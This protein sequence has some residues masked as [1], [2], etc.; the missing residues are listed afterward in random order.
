M[1]PESTS[2]SSA[3]PPSAAARSGRRRR[4]RAAPPGRRPA[5]PSNATAVSGEATTTSGSAP[6][7]R[8]PR[9]PSRPCGGRAAGGGAWASRNASACLGRRP[10]RLLRA[11]SRSRVADGWGARIR[12]WDHGTKT[13]CLTAWPRPIEGRILPR[14]GGGRSAS[15]PVA[16]Q[17]DEG[18]DREQH[19]DDD[20]DQR[21]T[22][23]ATTGTTTSATLGE[24]GD[25]RQLRARPDERPSRPSRRRR[26]T[27]PATA[28][29]T[30][31]QAIPPAS[32]TI[33][34]IAATASAI[35][36]AVAPEPAAARLSPCS[37]T[38][39]LIAA[40]TVP[41]RRR[42]AGAPACPQARRAASRAL[43]RRREEPVDGRAGAAD[44]GAERSQRASSS[45]ERRR[46]EVVRRAARARSPGARRAP[47]RRAAR[48]ALLEAG[49]AAA[50]V[51]APVDRA[52]STP[53]PRRPVEQEHRR[54][55]AAGRAA[56]APSRRRGRAAGPS[57]GRTAR[58]PRAS[59]RARAAARRRAASRQRRVRE[60]QRRGRVRAAAAETCRDRDPLRRCVTRQRGSTPR[61]ARERSR[62]RR[63]IVSSA[64][65]STRS[66]SAGS[67]CDRRRASTR[68]S[69]VATSC[70]PSGRSGPT[71]SARLIFAGAGARVLMASERLGQRDELAGLERLGA[72]RRPAGRSPRAPR[73][74][75]RASRRRR[76]A[77]AFGER[78]AAVGE[79]ALDDAATPASSPAPRPA[80]TRRARSRRSAAAG[81]RSARPGGSRF[82]RAVEL[83]EHGHGAVGLRRR[84]GE[85]P[86]GD[87][88]LHHHAPAAPRVGSPSGSRRPAAS[89]CCTAGSRRASSAAGASDARSSRER[90][91][92]DEL[93]VR[94]PASARARLGSSE[95]S[96]STA[97]TSADAVGEVARQ[98]AETRADL[99]H[100][101][102]RL[103]LGEPADHAEDVLV[104]EEV[105]AERLLRRDGWH[106]HGR[107]NAAVALASIC[108]ASSA[109]VLAAHVGEHAN[110]WTT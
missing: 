106:A 27:D 99:E 104:D 103:E 50:L 90:V 55:P 89:R 53:S 101:V 15:A 86:V 94:R 1:S 3:T 22:K 9:P 2:T 95:R 40:S 102:V 75:A 37:I 78:L 44:V 51:E 88:A 65:P 97:W 107:P 48:R 87:L 5:S 42:H 47:A 66:P 10:S 17:S 46:R 21:K 79:R 84:D 100:D 64:N 108:A 41:A 19:D 18:D 31:H 25:P 91:A 52:A 29:T 80:G 24:R 81:R 4:C 30:T 105:L 32:T 12:T 38:R 76:A 67:S 28:S 69:T 36:H 110:V 7:A 93:D 98:H 49:R 83:D 14:R 74:R 39:S 57:R 82:A 33:P 11:T 73:P 13:R 20:R 109:G 85:E 56:R 60:A 96:S 26:A 72:R 45:G 54:S 68:W 43:P 92:E 71:T 62:A 34:S 61:L 6:S 8:P 58:P 63:T 16:R 35:L 59:P 23:A 77:S 70:L